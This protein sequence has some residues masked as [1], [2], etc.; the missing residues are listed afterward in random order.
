V[1]AVILAAGAG[2]RFIRQDPEAA[3]GSKLLHT[4]RSQPLVVWS[5]APALEARLNEVVVVDGAADLGAVMPAGVTLLHNDRWRDGQA[6]T[7]RLALDWC[8]H[9]GH[10]AAVI[11]L[12]DTPGLTPAAWRSVATASEG[13]IVFATY[14]GQRG[15]P[16]RLDASVWPLLPT[17][18]EEGARS[19]ARDRPELV[20]EV[21]CEGSPADID[22]PEALRQW[23]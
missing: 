4:V 2:T 11:G 3:S 6:T 18:G 17:I 22:T 10:L 1:A 16:V 23:N 7:L 19:V 5:I 12:G 20:R 15:H 14:G 21:P 13:P 9:Q 8:A